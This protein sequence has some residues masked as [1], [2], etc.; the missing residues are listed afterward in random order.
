MPTKQ[1]FARAPKDVEVWGHRGASAHLPENT[2]VSLLHTL[3]QLIDSLA[4][5]RAAIKEGCDGIES[6]ESIF[7]DMYQS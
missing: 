7:H 5:F 4:S 3:P 6:G 2:Y 1:I